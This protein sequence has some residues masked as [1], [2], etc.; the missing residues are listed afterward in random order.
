[1][2]K[3]TQSP[4]EHAAQKL[5]L[6]KQKGKH[7]LAVLS[8]I[9]TEAFKAELDRCATKH[10]TGD[11]I[12]R[13]AINACKDDKLARAAASNPNSLMESLMKC[14]A[15]GLE[16]DGRHAHLVPYGNSVQFIADYKGLVNICYRT[17]QVH[18]V[19]ADVVYEGDIFRYSAGKCTGH[20]PWYLRQ[21][22]FKPTER[23]DIIAVYCTVKLA[24]GAE[25]CEVMSFEESEALRERSPSKNNGPWK[26][27][28]NEMRKKG[29]FKRCSKWLPFSAE[30][31]RA[32]NEDYDAFPPIQ[33]EQA[34]GGMRGLKQKLAAISH[35]AEVVDV[36]REDPETPPESDSVDTDSDSVYGEQEPVTVDAEHE[37][38]ASNPVAEDEPPSTWHG[39]D[40]QK[41]LM[42]KGHQQYD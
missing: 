19:H 9:N 3:K 25:K 13:I 5:A 15:Y 30:E 2:A 24:N 22:E 34:T 16:P 17:G 20:V 40:K 28:P 27:D 11:R 18:S 42:Q 36:P 31:K 7:E 21:D 29:V 1:M 37:P 26:T 38:P 23:G 35:D 32:F 8:T 12:V 41:E 4:K 14:S 6:A 10:L 39:S 33:R